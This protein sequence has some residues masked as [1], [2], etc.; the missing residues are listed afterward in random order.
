MNEWIYVQYYTKLLGT[1]NFF[2][3]LLGKLNIVISRNIC[4]TL[5]THIHE[6]TESKGN[7]IL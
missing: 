4:N 3:I 5:E 2:Y 7:N 6:K 1:L